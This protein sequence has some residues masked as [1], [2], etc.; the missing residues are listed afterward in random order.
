M[1]DALRVNEL[2]DLELGSFGFCFRLLVDK[3]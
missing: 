1:G 3:M 2:V